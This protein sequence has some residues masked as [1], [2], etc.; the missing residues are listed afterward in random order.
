V[1]C[2]L[3]GWWGTIWRT[4]TDRSPEVVDATKIIEDYRRLSAPSEKL[5]FLFQFFF[6]IFFAT[7]DR[8]Q[9]EQPLGGLKISCVRAF[10]RRGASKFI[11]SLRHAA[12]EKHK[13]QNNDHDETPRAWHDTRET[14]V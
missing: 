3:V 9:R 8:A 12:T 13:Q 11:W 14:T 10:A 1:F 4:S 6:V 2:A 5:F 7:P